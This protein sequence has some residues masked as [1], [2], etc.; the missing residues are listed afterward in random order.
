MP[1]L[2]ARRRQ[3]PGATAALGAQ[4]GTSCAGG[5]FA[6][7][8]TPRLAAV[9]GARPSASH[10][11]ADPGVATVGL[12]AASDTQ[13]AAAHAAA[14]DGSS[15]LVVP[16]SA[17]AAA[18]PSPTGGSG[19]HPAATRRKL[20]A[21]AARAARQGEGSWVATDAPSGWEPITL[22]SGR[23]FVMAATVKIAGDGRPPARGA[24]S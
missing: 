19:S 18:A 11:A 20:S 1:N 3:N 12:L 5:V 21:G 16:S 13:P 10:R 8:E 7:G 15:R 23:G 14:L 2:E 4:G 22:R 9:S 6:A 24:R 17:P